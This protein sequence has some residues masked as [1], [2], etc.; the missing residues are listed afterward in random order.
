MRAKVSWG[1]VEARDVF[2]LLRNRVK[3]RGRK[4]KSLNR[5]L[6]VEAE[7][8]TGGLLSGSRNSFTSDAFLFLWFNLCVFVSSVVFCERRL[9]TRAGAAKS[10]L[11]TGNLTQERKDEEKFHNKGTKAAKI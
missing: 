1:A 9:A 6:T 5:E 11:G 7:I 8:H 3:T 10:N 2:G 4:C